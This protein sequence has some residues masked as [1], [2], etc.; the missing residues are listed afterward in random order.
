M[1][2]QALQRTQMH[3]QIKHSLSYL[4]DLI[5]TL[6]GLIAYKFYNS[7]I[8]IKYKMFCFVDMLYRI[9]YLYMHLAIHAFELI[10]TGI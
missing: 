1:S 6:A 2:F 8:N 7:Q 5:P 3:V 10:V 9:F 4:Q